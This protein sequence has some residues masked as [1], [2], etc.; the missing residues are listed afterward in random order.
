MLT[1]VLLWV[2][3]MVFTFI[4]QYQAVKKADRQWHINAATFRRLRKKIN[5]DANRS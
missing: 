1:F 3:G 2:L 5:Q 4:A